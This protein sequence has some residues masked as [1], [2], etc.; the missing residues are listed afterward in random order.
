MWTLMLY[1]S[2][3]SGNLRCITDPL[4]ACYQQRIPNEPLKQQ[5][6]TYL[7]S[8]AWCP[9]FVTGLNVR[10]R[11]ISCPFLPTTAWRWCNKVFFKSLWFFCLLELQIN[12]YEIVKTIFHIS[13][14]LTWYSKI[15]QRT[16]RISKFCSTHELT[17]QFMEICVK[18]C[19]I[20]LK[21]N[22][23]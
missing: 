3:C 17:K 19:A 18:N 16:T 20:N 9:K 12:N 2:K 11:I 7:H 15:V 21:K 5:K 1:C 23:L 4:S 22:N 13:H 6:T 8:Q 10:F 14:N